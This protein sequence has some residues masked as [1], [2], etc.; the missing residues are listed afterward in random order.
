MQKLLLSIRTHP[1]RAAALVGFVTAMAAEIDGILH[2]SSRS[3]VLMFL[4]SS[5]YRPA[6]NEL[7]L[8]EAAFILFVAI[9]ANV[10]AYAALISAPTA[11]LVTL[12]RHF[13]RRRAG[14][15]H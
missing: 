8:A 3:V 14:S 5:D 6:I 15:P 9:V 1:I 7:H 10:I 13:S 4:P 12:S 2:H 11:L